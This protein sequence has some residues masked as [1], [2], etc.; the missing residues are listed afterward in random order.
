MSGNGKINFIKKSPRVP[1]SE[2]TLKKRKDGGFREHPSVF[3]KRRCL[4]KF[5][6]MSMQNLADFLDIEHAVIELFMEAKLAVDP[7]LAERLSKGTNFGAATWLE[8]Q[9]QY[10][11]YI[12]QL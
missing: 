1:I 5:T 11:E 10:D 2:L 4:H 12:K 6:D 8:L 7:E 9:R 3:F